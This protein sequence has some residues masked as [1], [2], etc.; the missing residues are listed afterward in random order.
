MV[1]SYGKIETEF[2]DARGVMKEKEQGES[3]V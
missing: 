3:A 2:R 1:K